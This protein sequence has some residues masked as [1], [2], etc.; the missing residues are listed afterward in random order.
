MFRY[1]FS[2]LVLILVSTASLQAEDS[3]LDLFRTR[4]SPIL[5]S[6]NP[7]S[8][9]E[10]HLSGVD[11]KNYIGDTQEE[12]FAS[13]KE[14]GLIDMKHPD[15]SKL[16]T[17]IKRAPEKQT[18]VS[19]KARNLEYEAFRAW[20]HAAVKDPKVA[21]AKTETNQLGP[22]LP[23]EVIRHT[24][25]DRVVGSFVENVWT[26]I[27]RCVSCHS[28]EMNRKMIG[29]NDNTKEDIDAIS[30][31]VPRNPAATLDKLYES[32]NIDTDD[33]YASLMLTKP[34]GL[35]DHGGGPKF[36]VGSRTDKNYR[37][38]LKDYAAILNDEYQDAKE[39][40]EPSKQVAFITKQNLRIVDLPEKFGRKLL[41][42]DIYRWQ[43]DKWSETPWGTAENA[44]AGKRHMWQ[45]YVLATAP[46]DSARAKKLKPE[47][48]LPGGRYLIKIYI[49][50]EDK[51]KADR[52][53]VLGPKEFYGQVEI[54]GPWK[55]GYQPPKIIHAPVKD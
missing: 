4:I 12:T 48:P 29:R 54:K 43:G 35:S 3:A 51:V 33:P 37:R 2:F 1:H 41:R 18:P 11:L 6:S 10:C 40:P 39:L 24:R 14:A 19:E 8:C 46:R 53:Y 32:G 31:V 55:V 21:A 16:L 30:W 7:S 38:F 27:G 15:Q 44:I 26:E 36:A 52:D 20:I 25:Q 45:S 50:Q 47:T 5:K 28:A 17:F 23:L 9:T 22:T 13:L 49:D 34:S 42:A